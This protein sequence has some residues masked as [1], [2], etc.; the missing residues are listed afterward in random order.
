MYTVRAP[1][2]TICT[3][4][5]SLGQNTGTINGFH[6]A[7]RSV[8]QLAHW[9]FWTLFWSPN[10]RQTTSPNIIRWCG[11]VSD[12]MSDV[13]RLKCQ[14]DSVTS[15]FN[16]ATHNTCTWPPAYTGYNILSIGVLMKLIRHSG[17]TMQSNVK[18]QK[19][20]N[21]KNIK[22]L[23][24]RLPCQ[25]AVRAASSCPWRSERQQT[26]TSRWS[27]SC[28]RRTETLDSWWRS[29]RNAAAG[30][31]NA[32]QRSVNRNLAD[33]TTLLLC[34]NLWSKCDLYVL[35]QHGVLCEVQ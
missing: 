5:S 24:H 27:A 30:C 26:D 28:E 1:H 15:T 4:T 17:S 33:E 12:L 35:G 14:D 2:S 9:S 3:L 23:R 29:P 7:I 10:F 6:A 19:G 32:G 8:S 16:I 18:K 22:A 13:P 20:K 11:L 21:I 25:V 34:S 31:N